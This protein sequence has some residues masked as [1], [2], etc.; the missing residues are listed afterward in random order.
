MVKKTGDGGSKKSSGRQMRGQQQFV[1]VKTSRKRTASSTRWLQRQLNDPYV[2]E[3]KKQGLR[4]RAAFKIIQLDEE[5]GLFRPGMRIVDLGAAPG[6]WTQVAVEKVQPEKTGGC[7]VGIDYL[8]MEDMPEATFLQADFNDAD[9]PDKLK[10][11][12]AGKADLVMSDMAAPTTGHKQTDHLKIMGLVELAYE[13][14]KEVLEQDGVF[15]AK[16]FQGGAA[17]SLLADL[18]R[19]FKKV[20]HVKPNASR[21]DSSEIYVVATGFRG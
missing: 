19:D 7:I 21:S 17:T 9:A 16:V 18:K 6:G 20:K 13:F 14:A 2:A 10:A 12:L 11:V 4:S 15:L 3:A 1:K 8:E 5:L